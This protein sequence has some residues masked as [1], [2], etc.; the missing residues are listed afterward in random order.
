MAAGRKEQ[1]Q[2]SVI[3]RLDKQVEEILISPL[4][5]NRER[6]RAPRETQ[7][8]A[9]ESHEEQAERASGVHQNSGDP[10]EKGELPVWLL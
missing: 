5:K 9:D 2:M 8:D 6:P 1:A 7:T 10:V 4:D 3:G